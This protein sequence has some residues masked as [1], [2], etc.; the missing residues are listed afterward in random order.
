VDKTLEGFIGSYLHL[1]VAYEGLAD[2]RD[3]LKTFSGDAVES[4]KQ[5]FAQLIASRELS[6]LDYGYLTQMEFESDQALYAYLQDVYDFLFN[7]AQKEP[8]PPP[9]G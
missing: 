6:A 5:N 2:T 1:E 7:S 8:E 3:V 9:Y 4:L